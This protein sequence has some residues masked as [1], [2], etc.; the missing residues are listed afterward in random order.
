MEDNMRKWEGYEKG[1][2]LGGWYSQCDYS[3]ERYDTFIMEKDMEIISKRGYDH[4]RLPF[5]YNLLEA[6]DGYERLDKVI[7]WCKNYNLNIILDLHKTWGYSFDAG[8]NETGFFEQESYQEKFYALWEELA[9]RYGN[10]GSYVSFE[11]LN[12]LVEKE[13][14]TQWFAIAKTCVERIRVIAKDVKILLGGYW[15]NSVASVQDLPKAFDEN[16]VYNFHCYEPLIF[17]H[18]GAPWVK[19]MPADFRC[20]CDVT[21]KEFYQWTKEYIPDCGFIYQLPDIDMDKKMDASFF[22]QIF[23][24]AVEKAEKENVALYCGEYGVIDLANK[25][26][27]K[28]WY[29]YIEE[30]FDYYGIGRAAW[31]YKEM[32]FEVEKD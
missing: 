22:I 19:G 28:T 8:E 2:N 15:N 30:A 3:K 7:E 21:V 31:T 17:T 4:V 5:D 24:G 18:Q 14:S 20:T 27:T 9:K 13:Y 1:I 25:N 12:E 26:D 23:K 6:Q 11:L 16:V 29:G 10:L 32:D